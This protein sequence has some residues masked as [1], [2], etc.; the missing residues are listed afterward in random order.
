[1]DNSLIVFLINDSARAIKGQYED[2]GVKTLFKT[3]DATINVDDFAVVESST[4]HELTVVKV[5]EVDVDINFD[6][7]KNVKWVVQKIDMPPYKTVLTQ[8]REAISA[9]QAAERA[10]KKEELRATMFA[11]HE[12][13]I[14]ALSLSTAEQ[15]EPISE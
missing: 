15:D 7:E 3:F 8:E 5:T 13:K 14:K 10:R 4:R 2:G 6:T 12:T 9:V 11:N 1:M